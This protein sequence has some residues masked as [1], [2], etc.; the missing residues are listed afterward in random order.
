MSMFCYEKSYSPCPKGIGWGTSFSAEDKEKRMSRT[1][2]LKSWDCLYY[3]NNWT[4][5]KH[6]LI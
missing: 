6:I 4:A 2:I 5:F 1:H 3:K